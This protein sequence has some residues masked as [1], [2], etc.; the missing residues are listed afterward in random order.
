MRWLT[1][2]LALGAVGAALYAVIEGEQGTQS[3]GAKLAV[4]IALGAVA[5]WTA[6][7]SARHRRREEHARALQLELT[8]FAPFI[9][10]L[11]PEQREEER[12]R[13]TRKTFGRAA[14]AE[15]EP[16]DE[17]SPSAVSVVLQR[18][19]KSESS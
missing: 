9:E 1:I 4:S 15:P 13:M 3:L 10:P 11:I 7:Q 19:Q 14:G 6:N 16:D 5:A 8:A 12:V 18:F 2:A 17:I